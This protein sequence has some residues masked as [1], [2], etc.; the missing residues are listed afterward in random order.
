MSLASACLILFFGCGKQN[1]RNEF[2][3][4]LFQSLFGSTEKI[5]SRSTTKSVKTLNEPIGSNDQNKIENEDPIHFDRMKTEKDWIVT[6]SVEFSKTESNRNVLNAVPQECTG[7]YVVNLQPSAFVTFLETHDEDCSKVFLWSYDSNSKRIY[8]QANLNAVISR[9][10]AIAPSYNGT[11]DL[12]FVQLLQVFWAGYYLKAY[13]SLDFDAAQTAQALAQ[14]LNAMSLSPNFLNAGA[15]S[16][17]VLSSFFPVVNN[18]GIG[19]ALYTP[20]L[21]FLEVNVSNPS[22]VNEYYQALALNSAFL[23]IQRQTHPNFSDFVAKV[24]ASLIDKLRRLALLQ[25]FNNDNQVWILNNAIYSLDRI[26]YYKTSF[27]SSIF[28]AFTDVLTTYAYLSEPYLWAIQGLTRRRD[29]VTLSIGQV[30]LSQTKDAVKAIAFPY[31]YTFDDGVQV[32]RTSVPLSTIQNIYH[33]LKQVESQFFRLVGISAPVPGDP[34]DSISMYIYGTMKEYQLYQPFLFNLSTNNGG[35]YIEQNKAFYTY[36]RTS[37][38]SIYTLEELF[39]HEY[40]HYLVGRFVVPGL[41]SEVP[42]YN[43]ERMTWF[44]EGIAE[45]LAGS[46]QKTILPRKTLVSQINTDGSSGRMTVS[47]I[48]SA[49]YSDFKFY[50]YSGNFFYYLYSYRKETLKNLIDSLRDSN[51]QNFDTIVYQMSQDVSLN[52]DYQSNLDFLI[53]DLQNLTNPFTIAPNLSNLSTADPS[54]IQSAFRTTTVGYAAKCTNAFFGNNGRFSCRGTITGSLRIDKNWQAS[55]TE[56][57]NQ[58]NNYLITPLASNSLNNFGSMICRLGPI[59]FNSYSTQYYPLALYSCEG[60][61]PSGPPIA[62]QSPIQQQADFRDTSKGTNTNCYATWTPALTI[63]CNTSL[64][65]IS[66][67]GVTSYDEMYQSLNNQFIN[68]KSEVFLMRPA[69]YRKINCSL[70][71]I[72]TV[73]QSNGNKYLVGTSTCNL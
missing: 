51:I 50:R 43:N 56:L 58:I 28:A 30:C 61:F 13:N 63:V 68:L 2:D 48:L 9:L 21:N 11:N 1:D 3:R 57:N 27:E 14:P 8:S 72:N 54:V 40:S 22:R 46:T 49:R 20:L 4:R 64:S 25:S 5:Q 59:Y 15:D 67:P 73:T 45:F 7:S 55:W 16:G 34:T 29:C 36:Q 53:R 6:P 12:K 44:D 47:Q 60:P 35:I 42:V 10:N 39:R 65:T 31:T 37:A 24:D 32:V 41:W 18:A 17:Y 70:G 62:Y 52:S 23:L 71:S 33:A 26:A 38:E 66:F 19:A 69:F